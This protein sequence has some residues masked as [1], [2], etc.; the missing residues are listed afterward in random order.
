MDL[1]S[2]GTSIGTT[3]GQDV[4]LPAAE[5]L[6]YPTIE[7][8]R[9]LGGSAR[10]DEISEKVVELLDLSEEQQSI[11][12]GGRDTRS[13]LEYRLAWARTMA[14]NVGVLEN[15]ERGVWRLT[16]MGRD[17]ERDDY[18]RLQ[19]EWEATRRGG[20]ADEP[21]KAAKQTSI[22]EIDNLAEDAWISTLLDILGGMDPYAIE[23]LFLRLLREAGF[24][25][26]EQTGGTG[27]GGIDGTGVYRVSL[28]S[29]R[30][31]FQCKRWKGSVGASEVRDFRGAME[32][33]GERGLLVTTS[34]S[35][36]PRR[37]KRRGRALRP[38]T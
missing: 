35:Q 15:S 8:V 11:P 22:E 10:I 37:M 5:E 34:S 29:F 3:V 4:E 2:H 36:L 19:E 20:H 23:R 25:D 16:D 1:A 30:V 32:G 6:T 12:Q 31:Y 14:K 21:L 26:L 13:K 9:A 28:V 17:V 18:Y 33:R 27:D 24:D 7:A 38:L